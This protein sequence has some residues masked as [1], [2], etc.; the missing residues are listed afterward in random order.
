MHDEKLWAVKTRQE[1]KKE[2]FESNDKGELVREDGRSKAD[3]YH[4]PKW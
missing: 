2:T 1:K 3:L 4:R